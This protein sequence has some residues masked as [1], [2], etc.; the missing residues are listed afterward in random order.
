M[1]KIFG[2]ASDFYRARVLTLEEEVPPDFDWRD[3]ILYHTP[4]EHESGMK[5]NYCLQI[6]DLD[7]RKNQNLK[8]YGN[9]REAE[10]ALQ[11][12]EEDLKELTKM[13]FEKR[14]DIRLTADTLAS[15]PEEGFEDEK[16][17]EN[18]D[19]PRNLP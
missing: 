19:V 11:K 2:R 7:S 17:S 1:A 6:V 5:K 9:K 16:T 15:T 3:D 4:E 13:E 10:K 18:K 8:Q 12:I 14:Y